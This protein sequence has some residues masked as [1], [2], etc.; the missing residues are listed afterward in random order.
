M[1]CMDMLTFPSD[2]IPATPMDLGRLGDILRESAS[3][4]QESLLSDDPEVRAASLEL[5]GRALEAAVSAV[6]MLTP[7]HRS[8]VVMAR[9]V[10]GPW[11][12]QG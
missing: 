11:G 1:K 5:A 10:A 9:V 7:E 8:P 3:L 12:S 6:E 4:V 2:R